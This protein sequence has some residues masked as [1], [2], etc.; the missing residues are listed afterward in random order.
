[1]ARLL[2]LE[3]VT[4]G[5]GQGKGPVIFQPL[6]LITELLSDIDCRCRDKDL[7]TYMSCFSSDPSPYSTFWSSLAGYI[8][9]PICHIAGAMRLDSIFKSFWEYGGKW[10]VSA[11][12]VRDFYFLQSAN[13]GRES[14]TASL[15]WSFGWH[16]Q[17]PDG[18][19]ADTV[20][21][22]SQLRLPLDH[23][24]SNNKH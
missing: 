19:Q 3:E 11:L 2:F 10:P 8:G 18:Q 16:Q 4:I 17:A 14:F 6:A 21:R 22:L 24:Q 7:L 5:L 1:M 13:L 12:K 20:N 15:R 23:Q 9:Q